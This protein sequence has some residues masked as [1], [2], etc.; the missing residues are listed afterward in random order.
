VLCLSELLAASVARHGD[1]IALVVDGQAVSYAELDGLSERLAAFLQAQGVTRGDRVALHLRN[2]LAYVVADLAIA[3]TCAVKVPL[4]ELMAP[5]EISYCLDHAGVSVLIGESGLPQAGS[6][7]DFLHTRILVGAPQTAGGVIEWSTALACDAQREMRVP[8]PHDLAMIA[9]TGGTTGHPKGVCHDQHRLAVNLLAGIVCG[10]I[11]SDEVML[12]TTPLPHSAGYHL[13]ACLVQG[14]TIVLA[15]K[16]DPD[17]F[18]GLAAQHGATWTFAVPT[19]LY[20]L[21]DRLGST[22]PPPSL[23][24]IVYGAAPMS[25]A[26]LGEALR[27][28]GPVF[29]QIYGQTECPNFIT[30]LGK[31]E[32]AD[33]QLLT[34]CGRP[35]PFVDLRIGSDEG[36][37]EEPGAIGEIEVRSPYL[38]TGYYRNDDATSGA[39]SDGWLRTG[40]LAYRD[41]RGYVFLVDRA[42]DMI[43]TGG[44]NVYSV[45]VETVLRRHPAV[46]DAA[47]LGLADSDWGEA[48]VAVVVRR[49]EIAEASLR[50]SAREALSAY[51]VPKRIIFTDALPLTKYGKIDKKAL[52]AALSSLDQSSSA[53]EI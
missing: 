36:H 1:R 15:Q 17:S 31:D 25:P 19:M 47:V 46:A 28:F 49:A 20:R 24:T 52:R 32:H 27:L 11:R 45:E 22:P 23:R 2:G 44:M 14:G 21:L 39:M 50:A 9:Y 43:I 37:I 13:Q 7:P 16:F 34:S 10:D 6:I 48:V 8:A 18:L 30:T 33:G 29:I 35:V 12:L 51:K 5:E 38:L 40:D 4:N 53:E 3:K 42:K 41:G 26:R